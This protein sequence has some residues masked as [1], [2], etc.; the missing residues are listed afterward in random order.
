MNNLGFSYFYG[1]ADTGVKL[2]FGSNTYEV[3]EQYLLY[4]GSNLVADFGGF[5]GLL[6]SCSL[7]SFYDM[8]KDGIFRFYS[9]INGDKR[10]SKHT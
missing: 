7:L 9:W 5:L 10:A 8:G 2:F 3:K 1:Y 6:L 4:G